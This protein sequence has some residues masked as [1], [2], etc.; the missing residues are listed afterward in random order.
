MSIL[1][2]SARLTSGEEGQQFAD[3]CRFGEI[4]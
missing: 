3:G 4:V 1:I 2:Q